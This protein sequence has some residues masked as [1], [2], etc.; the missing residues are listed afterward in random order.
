MQEEVQNQR[1]L[2]ND[3]E[4]KLGFSNLIGE[5]LKK[6]GLTPNEIQ[7]VAAISTLQSA[8]KEGESLPNWT[9]SLVKKIGGFEKLKYETF[10]DYCP[11]DGVRE[12]LTAATKLEKIVWTI[13]VLV[14]LIGVVYFLYRA[15]DDYNQNPVITTFTT[16]INETMIL[17]DIL[18]C[19]RVDYDVQIFIEALRSKNVTIE[20]EKEFLR[21]LALLTFQYE[22]HEYQLIMLLEKYGFN[23]TEINAITDNSQ[24]PW[25]SYSLIYD[26]YEVKFNDIVGI[27]YDEMFNDIVGILYDEMVGE[28]FRVNTARL[29]KEGNFIRKLYGY[30]VFKMNENDN[31]DYSMGVNFGIRVQANSSYG[32]FS[33]EL[34]LGLMDPSA[35]LGVINTSAIFSLNNKL[36]YV[37]Q[38]Y[39]VITIKP[40]KY[41][42]DSDS[43]DVEC[44]DS[45]DEEINQCYNLC[46]IKT[47]K[48]CNCS[49]SSQH[50]FATVEYWYEC[51]RNNSIDSISYCVDHTNRNCREKCHQ[52]CNFW[53]YEIAGITS[54]NF[55]SQ[56]EK[57][58][59]P[60]MVQDLKEIVFITI[61]Y[62]KLG[63]TSIKHENKIDSYSVVSNIGGLVSLW[64]GG[65]LISFA[66]CLVY[67]TMAS[68]GSYRRKRKQ[69]SIG[70]TET[71]K[72]EANQ[73]DL[74]STL[75]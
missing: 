8:T 20:K 10:K 73:L 61:L 44:S 60:E 36:A 28:C 31:K 75:S 42:L 32:M 29:M 23:E 13:I 2:S 41:E 66:Q 72:Q 35:N 56:I 63:Y 37:S 17:P 48:T 19:P 1:I 39:H 22:F 30:E 65:S 3:S 57:I 47:N 51:V 6:R 45:S 40:I 26:A 59:E 12:V 53:D 15:I 62:P 52:R 11:F 74:K 7:L 54:R 38:G 14:S 33:T 16:K 68:Y 55:D 69:N 34:A 49:S 21:R 64:L 50:D 9:Q 71:N 70:D 67:L 4:G 58:F 25:S 18:I 46:D 24:L 27:L 5:Q 43:P